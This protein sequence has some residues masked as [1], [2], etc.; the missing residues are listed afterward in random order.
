MSEKVNGSFFS[1]IIKGIF[2]ALT[3]ALGGILI[4]AGVVRVARLNE[5]VIKAGN[6]FIKILAIFLGCLSGV[7]V[8]RGAIKGSLIGLGFSLLIQLIFGIMGN[9]Q[10]GVHFILDLL[11]SLIVGGIAGII[12]ITIKG[13]RN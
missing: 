4:F 13:K 7:R 5:S 12:I 11:F 3:V 8:N 10:F 9:G 6:Q 2:I 1:R